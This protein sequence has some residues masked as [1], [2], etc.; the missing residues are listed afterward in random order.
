VAPTPHTQKVCG[1]VRPQGR[2]LAG[3]PVHEGELAPEPSGPNNVP[4][5]A[6][7][8]VAFH[9]PQRELYS[10]PGWCQRQLIDVPPLSTCRTAFVHGQALDRHCSRQVGQRSLERR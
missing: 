3:V 1:A 7:D 5:A 6:T 4:G 10:R 2:V 8:L 9:S